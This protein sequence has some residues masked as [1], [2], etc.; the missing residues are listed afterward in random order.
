MTSS[1]L[2]NNTRNSNPP[3][4][5]PLASPT[6]KIY[7]PDHPYELQK[8]KLRP[9]ENLTNPDED[10]F[11]ESLLTLLNGQQDLHKQFFNMMQDITHRHEYDNLMRDIPIYDRKN[12][13]LADWLLQI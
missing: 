3:Q 12:M 11:N 6:P 5:S 13:N 10:H 8:E 1:Q 2:E 4:I 7:L 9:M